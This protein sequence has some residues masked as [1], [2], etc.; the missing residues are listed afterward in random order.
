MAGEIRFEENE[1]R[2]QTDQLAAHMLGQHEL[3]RDLIGARLERIKSD[4][5]LPAF[6]GGDHRVEAAEFIFDNGKTL[7]VEAGPDSKVYVK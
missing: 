4:S 3:G 5:V 7:V 6:G 2:R 1:E